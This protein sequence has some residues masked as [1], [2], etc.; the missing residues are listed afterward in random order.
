MSLIDVHTHILSKAYTDLLEQHASPRYGLSRDSEGSVIVTRKGARF[1]T[2]TRPMFDPEIRLEAMDQVGVQL[3]LLS[4]TCPNC[5]WAEGAL[6]G[7][8]AR[9]MNDNLAEVC[10]RWPN[11]Y[12]GLASIPLQNAELSLR[13]LERAL[14]QLGLVGLI[15]LANVNEIPLDHPDFEP[16]WAELN[17]RRVPTLLHPTASPGVPDMGLGDYGL[18]PSIGFMVDTTLAVSRMALAGVFERYPDWPLIISHAGATLPYLAARLDQCYQFI[19]DAR[20][21]A[22]HPPQSLPET[23]LL[24]HR[25]V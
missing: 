13:E 23:A 1:M 7:E 22:P 12:R 6:A 15:I 14:D 8:V 24:R 25:D 3:E 19:P 11:R 4:Y 17:R 9:V 5:Y 20:A 2:F 18:I 16:V 10:A 21:K